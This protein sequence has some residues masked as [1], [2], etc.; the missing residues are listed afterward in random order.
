[1][2]KFVLE[3]SKYFPMVAWGIIA[4][5]SVFV[6]GLVVNL[7]LTAEDL[8]LST[9]NLESIVQQN[10]APAAALSETIE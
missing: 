7:R 9:E 5:F 4:C 2:Q 8:R 6:F 3:K 10:A 1:M